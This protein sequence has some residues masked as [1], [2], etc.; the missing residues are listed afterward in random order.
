VGLVDAT[1]LH[2]EL[3]QSIPEG[4]RHDASI[5]PFCVEKA[6]QESVPTSGPSGDEPSGVHVT[7][8]PTPEGGTTDMSNTTEAI[9]METHQAL[10]EKAT[11]DATS[12]L[13]SALANKTDELSAANTTIS[14]LESANSN[15]KAETER[16]NK[17]LDEAQVQLKVASDELASLK[18]EIAKRE[19]ESAKAELAAK[20]VEQIK[21]LNLFTNEYVTEKASKWAD[22]SDEDWADRLQEWQ[23]VKPA[24]AVSTDSASAITGTTESLTTEPPADHANENDK[25]ARRAVLGL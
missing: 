1:A 2:D 25:P 12:A 5:C 23:D 6:A 9:S 3:L 13:D 20:R 19:Q 22:L 8:N 11:K 21:E 24:A 14:E 18:S 4:A 16:L 15:L 10:L 17:E 7:S